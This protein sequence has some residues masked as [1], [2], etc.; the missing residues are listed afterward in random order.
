MSTYN[1][2]LYNLTAGTTAI[3]TYAGCNVVGCGPFS[4]AANVY[5][6]SMIRNYCKLYKL[7][8]PP[9]ALPPQPIPPVGYQIAA[10][11]SEQTLEIISAIL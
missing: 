11:A 5:L 3:V 9:S 7:L 8:T 10:N 2:T 4:P 1:Y 6:A